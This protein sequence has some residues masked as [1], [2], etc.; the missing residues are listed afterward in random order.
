[1]TNRAT[2]LLLASSLALWGCDDGGG[3]DA[4]AGDGG[5]GD[6]DGG[7]PSSGEC[8]D[9]SQGR[10][11]VLEAE[12]LALTEEWVVSDDNA[13]FTGDGYIEWTGPSRNNDPSHGPIEVALRFTEPGRYRLQWHTRIGRGT[14]TTEHNDVWLRF[15]DVAGFYGVQGDPTD[16]DRVYPRPQCEDDAFLDPIRGRDDVADASCP[17]GSSR[18]GYFE[19]YSSGADDWRSSAR[20]SD[21]DAHDVVVEIDEPGVYV[22]ELAARADFSQLDRIV[23]HEEGLGNDVVRDLSNPETRCD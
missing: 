4:G 19:I 21:R 8:D 11:L 17:A 7:R 22:M 20:T 10:L 5:G 15:T 23:W 13:G 1:M 12:N 16:E 3:G 6:G 2:G 14:N 18:D 9:E